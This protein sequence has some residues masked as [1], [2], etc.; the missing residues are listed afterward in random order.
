MSPQAQAE[1]DA[2]NAAI[3]KMEARINALAPDKRRELM[4][5]LRSHC[6]AQRFVLTE[7]DEKVIA[8][9]EK[10]VADFRRVTDQFHSRLPPLFG[11]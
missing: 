10:G 4:G 6:N 7:E 5:M 11:A 2:L 8:S 3:A 1:I 9:F